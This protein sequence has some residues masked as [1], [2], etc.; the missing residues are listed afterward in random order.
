MEIKTS[1]LIEKSQSPFKEDLGLPQ[2]KIASVVGFVDEAVSFNDTYEQSLKELYVEYKNNCRNSIPLGK[3]TF[4]K[5]FLNYA[6]CKHHKITVF[7]TP[8]GVVYQGAVL[9]K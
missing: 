1:P 6:D 4:Q 7:K 2:Y 5:V 3:L 8:R 9:T